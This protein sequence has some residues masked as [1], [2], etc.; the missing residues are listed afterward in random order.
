MKKVYCDICKK[1][2]DTVYSELIVD[3]KIIFEM[4]HD[5]SFRVIGHARNLRN[6]KEYNKTGDED[7]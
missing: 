4:C 2:I 3:N 1:E 6:Q 5:C 7:S